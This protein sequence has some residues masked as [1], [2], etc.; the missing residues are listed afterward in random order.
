M[1]LFRSQ[2]LSKVSLN[3]IMF[4]K[5]SNNSLSLSLC[6]SW[7]C[8]VQTCKNI[9]LDIFRL[10]AYHQPLHMIEI[11]IQ[12]S[13]IQCNISTQTSL[14][15]NSIDDR[16]QNLYPMFRTEDIPNKE[17]EKGH[18]SMQCTIRTSFVSSSVQRRQP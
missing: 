16:T 10:I 2:Q 15:Q 5:S 4:M 8:W 7:F 17:E 11:L 18:S 14:H 13:S 3:Q 9:L 6:G 12:Y 1:I